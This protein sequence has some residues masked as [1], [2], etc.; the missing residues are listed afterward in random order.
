MKVRI[1]VPVNVDKER[2]IEDMILWGIDTE[3]NFDFYTWRVE[4][5]QQAKTTIRWAVW[6]IEPNDYMMFVLRW[7]GHSYK[8]KKE[9]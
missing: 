1:K 4:N 7:D 8:T 9:K 5:F 2:Y 6:T 3:L